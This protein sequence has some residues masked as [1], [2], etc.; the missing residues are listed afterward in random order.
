[1]SKVAAVVTTVALLHSLAGC[2]AYINKNR[3]MNVQ[4]G[5][6]RDEVI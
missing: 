6:T 4:V 2:G 1:M 5:M 3:L